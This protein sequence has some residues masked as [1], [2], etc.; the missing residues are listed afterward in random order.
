MCGIAGV[1]N[2]TK[3]PSSKEVLKSK[4][5]SMIDIIDHRG[6]DDSGVFANGNVCLGSRRLS[7]LDLS[8]LGHMPMVDK[9]TGNCIVHNGEVYNYLEL[10]RSLGLNDVISNTDTEVILNAY[11]KLG[12][13]CV[14]EF[15]GM[16]AFA[17]WDAQ[18]K[19]LFMARDR[20]GIKPLF[21]AKYKNKIYFSSEIK[22]ILKAGIPFEPDM[23]IIYDYL[24]YGVYDHSEKTFFKNIKQI[25]AGYTLEL[26][27]NNFKLEKYWDLDPDLEINFNEKS[28]SEFN[29][30]RTT[31]KFL[32]LLSDS[33]Q[34]RL[35]S[36]VPIAVHISGGLDSSVML[37][38]INS[39]LGGQKNLRA[40]SY[41]YGEDKYDEKKY[42]EEIIKNGNWEAEFYRFDANDVPDL[43]K[44]AMWFQEQ[45]FPGIITLAKHKLI[46]KSKDYGAKVI[47]EGQ[48]GDDIGAGYQYVFASHV[49][50]LIESGNSDMAITELNN[51]GKING[52][53]AKENMGNFVNSLASYYNTGYSADG[54]S[55]LK[56]NCI[57]TDFINEHKHD[58]SFPKPFNSH[59]LNMQYR[60]TR[61]TKL[62][63]ILRSCDRASMA[64]SRELRVPFL[65]HRLVELMFFLPG[66]E[67]IKSGVQRVFM[68]DAIKNKFPKWVTSSPKKTV[69]DPQRE[70]LRTD[71]SEWVSDILHSS[72][73]NDLGILDINNVK[74][75]YK[76]Y[77]NTTNPKNSFFLWQWINICIWYETFNNN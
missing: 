63:R 48:G 9:K 37:S 65:D 45:P 12:K 55:F 71:L 62:P 72:S 41:Y 39:V 61:F 42:A 70:W 17:I 18:N 2:L 50:D 21:Y 76:N 68:R 56:H 53:N 4:V 6:P 46:S 49:L 59:L 30:F 5:S 67:K 28:K 8:D 75:E 60:D 58:L 25:P 51:F 32:D 27:N 19:K 54:S 15:N 33:L 26:N 38:G 22:S 10:K 73:F 3:E 11:I 35:R 1:Y 74:E 29:N 7:I 24:V 52:Y 13:S 44:K 20:L 43:T 57:N 14:H 36:D 16:F 40:F 69:V 47:L 77:K 34:L 23:D 66:G 31:E 64:S